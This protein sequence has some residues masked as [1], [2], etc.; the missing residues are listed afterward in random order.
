[1]FAEG[2]TVLS[3]VEVAALVKVSVGCTGGVSCTYPVFGCSFCRDCITRLA[4]ALHWES[5]EP[6]KTCSLFRSSEST[7]SLRQ[8]DLLQHSHV[9]PAINNTN[10]RHGNNI[11]ITVRLE[12]PPSAAK[13][14]GEVDRSDGEAVFDEGVGCV[15]AEPR[16]DGLLNVPTAVGALDG[17]PVDSGT[18]VGNSVGATPARVV[19]S[20]TTAANCCTPLLL[21]V[22]ASSVDPAKSIWEVDAL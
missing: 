1:M 12:A 5:V 18:C 16:S 7:A 20:S 4:E 3:E 14:G 2:G 22:G 15:G 11:T 10:A 17:E 6:C 21:P 13:V 9:A 8:R 19:L